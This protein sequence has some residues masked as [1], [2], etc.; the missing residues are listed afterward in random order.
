[1]MTNEKGLIFNIQKYCVHDGPGIR[2]IVFFKGCPLACQW[3]SNPEGISSQPEISYKKSKC[4][5]MDKCAYCAPVCPQQAIGPDDQG[6]AQIDRAKCSAC[7]ACAEACPAKDMEQMGRWLSVDEVLQEVR[8]DEIFYNRSGGGMTLSGGE[9][10]LQ[11]DFALRLLRQAH[12]EGLDTAIETTGCVPWEK[13]EAVFGELDFIHM[14]IKSLNTSKH[15]AFTGRGNELILDNFTKL[16]AHFPRKPLLVRTPIIPGFN[17][18]VE[19]IQAIAD[20][21]NRAAKNM[22]DVR[23]ELLPFHN[24]GSSKY[25]FQGKPYRYA[26]YKNMDKATAEALKAQIRSD[27][28]LLLN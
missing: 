16:C 28:P 14:D 10:L 21:V 25:D 13:A 2:S 9:P 6:L 11:A 8:A 15:K 5:G 12:D 3:C 1:M 22:Q 24:F 20:F 27:I 18:T 7:L 19:D 17:D 26:N 23:Y 4:M